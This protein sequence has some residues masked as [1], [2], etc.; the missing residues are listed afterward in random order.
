MK[1]L[2]EQSLK[3]EKGMLLFVQNLW[4]LQTNN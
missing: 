4:I 2:T 3:D 1:F